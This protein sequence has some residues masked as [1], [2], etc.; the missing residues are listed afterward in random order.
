M[1][2]EGE[3]PVTH[4]FVHQH[5][6]PLHDYV[7]KPVIDLAHQA[8]VD[9][10]ELPDRLREA[11]RLLA[12]SDVFPFAAGASQGLDV[13]HTLP[14][15]AAGASRAERHWSTRLGNLGPLTRTHHRIKTHG[16]WT[17]RQPFPGI[18]LWRDPHGMLYL[19]DHTG[20]HPV[21]APRVH[22]PDVDLYPADNLIEADFER[23]AQGASH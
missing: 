7:I 1:R 17:V 22:D 6:R 4:A 20:T 11:V 21:G 8:P 16:A 5:L 3:G 19:E 14:Y 13:D 18:Y 12:P 2:W 10:Y 15:D 9:A 23:Q